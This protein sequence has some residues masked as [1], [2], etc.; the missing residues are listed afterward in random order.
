MLHTQGEKGEPAHFVADD[1]S[2][3]MGSIGP[4]GLKVISLFLE[5]LFRWNVDFDFIKIP[6][7]LNGICLQG[8]AGLP[9]PAG[10]QVGVTIR[11]RC[12]YLMKIL[13]AHL[14]KSGLFPLKGPVGPVGPK[15]ELGFPGRPV[16]A[17]NAP[18]VHYRCFR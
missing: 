11:V 7:S 9:G 2:A 6:W 12:L 1:G 13:S 4:R 15:G 3:M 18:N 16:S 5:V 8:D 10:V 14:R 17:A